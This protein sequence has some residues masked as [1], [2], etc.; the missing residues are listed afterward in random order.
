MKAIGAGVSG[1]NRRRRKL[2]T[3]RKTSPG[4]AMRK[5]KRK[6]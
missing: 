4:A 5:R 3:Y 2:G 1:G 6:W